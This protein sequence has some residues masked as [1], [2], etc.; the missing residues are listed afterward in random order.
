M[1]EESSLLAALKQGNKKA[2]SLL[3]KTYYR[4]M[5]LFGGS[6][7]PEQT[8]CEDIVQSVFLKLWND[9]SALD[10]Q[11]SLKA[12]LL[13][14]VRNGCLD[15]LRHRRIMDDHISSYTHSIL[16]DIDTENYILYSDLLQQL[17]NALEKLPANYRRAFE[18]NRFEG[19]KYKEIADQLQVSERTVEV[20]IS[21]ALELL[22]EHLKDF[23]FLFPGFF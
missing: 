4:D 23:L 3:F 13:K 14:A 12:Y 10:I 5:V 21:K 1:T 16:E 2:F 22:R 6:I 11:S 19:L 20:R 8:V 18:M 15:E 7:L 9:H 17:T